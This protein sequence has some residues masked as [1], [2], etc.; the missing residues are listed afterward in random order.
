MSIFSTVLLVWQRSLLYPVVWLFPKLPKW[1]AA[2]LV[3]TPNRGQGVI[4][5]FC[6]IQEFGKAE[7]DIIATR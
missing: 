7:E 6:F 2:L 3:K 5:T 4:Q 1:L